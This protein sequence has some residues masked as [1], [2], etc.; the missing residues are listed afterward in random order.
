MSLQKS[1]VSQLPSGKL[2]AFLI[3]LFFG[4]AAQAQ[5]LRILEYG[6]NHIAGTSVPGSTVKLYYST[7][8]NDVCT[9]NA[10]FASVLADRNGNWTYDGP[11]NGTFIAAYVLGPDP[12]VY[13]SKTILLNEIEITGYSCNEL[14][15]IK[16]KRPHLGFDVVWKNASG[17]TIALGG[18][19]VDNL[20]PGMYSIEYRVAGS[21]VF[22]SEPIIVG[23][24]I[25][26][27]QTQEFTL[28]CNET[29]VQVYGN[30]TPGGSLEK[31]YRWERQSDG[32]EVGDYS[33]IRLTAGKY[34][35]SIKDDSGCWSEKAEIIVNPPASIP[36]IRTSYTVNDA[37][38]NQSNGSITGIIATTTNNEVLTYKWTDIAGK[39]YFMKDLINVPSG[40]YT[41]AV[42]AG[43]GSCPAYLPAI[44]IGEKNAIA[45]NTSLAVPRHTSCGLNNGQIT[46][47]VTNATKFKWVNDLNPEVTISTTKDLT[48]A[49]PGY[50]TLILG[51][52]FDCI[53]SY[54]PFHIKES[55]PVI[56][57]TGQPLIKNDNCGLKIGSITGIKFS[58]AVKSY[59]WLNAS[60][61]EIG[62]NGDLLNVP[63][64][65]YTL[66]VR[67]DQCESRFNYTVENEETDIDAPIMDDIL[68]CDATTVLGSFN[69]N[70]DLYRIYDESGVLL[71]EST[72]KDFKIKV[73]SQGIY[74]AA[75]ARG[76]CESSRTAFKIKFGSSG[77]DIPSAFSPNGDGQNDKW[78]IKGIDVYTSP[79]IRIFNRQ[80]MLVFHSYGKSQPFEG[81]EKG[82]DLPVGVYYY[83]VKASTECPATSGSLT[84]IR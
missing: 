7:V 18:Q 44:N 47:I 61:T 75:L 29:E 48:N 23:N 42:S 38:C 6:S 10:E 24:R 58:S 34:Y 46:G 84:L 45:I 81:K 2:W 32:A 43:P 8:V 55:D 63:A 54:G 31:Y 5:T 40:L 51:N 70:A 16:F 19:G 78:I 21:C 33:P 56:Y 22:K 39:N 3:L 4:I 76:T 49:S 26:Q 60:N 25:P 83:L 62:K 17:S 68:V 50:Y 36:V 57:I 64:G 11:S 79:E 72:G 14:G 67:N 65:E 28:G 52:D 35:L 82:V 41:L 80:G 69:D 74:Y 59:V 30:Y 37:S 66:I 13:E 73:A 1:S 15:T 12:P 53:K 9:P 20:Q 77:L 71:N 27:V